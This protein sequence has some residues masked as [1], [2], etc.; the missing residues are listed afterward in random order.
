MSNSKEEKVN[1]NPDRIRKDIVL[2]IV[3]FALIGAYIFYEC[4]TATHVE[5]ETI[6]AVTSTVYDSV[7]AKALVVRDEHLVNG[8][9]GAVTVP[10]VSDGEKVKLGGNIAMVFSSEDNAKNYSDLTELHNQLDY[11]NELESKA[12]GT[13]TDVASI[14]KDILS[15]VN[16]YIRVINSNSYSSL[17]SCTDDLND[18]LARRQMIIGQDIDFSAVKENLQ[19]QINGINVDSCKPTGYITTDESGIFSSYTDGFEST[20][21]YKKITSVD[22]DTLRSY[23]ESAGTVQP[24]ADCIGKLIMDYNWY[25]CCVLSAEDVKEIS[26]GD[27]LNVSLKD[28]DK[29]LNCEVVSG[30]DVPLGQ[31]ETVLILKCSEIDGEITSMRVE[32]IEIRFNEYSGFKVPASA[33]HIDE[34][35]NKC[36]YALIA[37][38]VAKRQSEIIYST[39]DYVVFDRDSENSDSIRFYDQI[40]TKGKDLHDGKIYS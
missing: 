34:D 1:N 33:V 40:I 12:A 38:Q 13:A 3:M 5:V 35:G 14:D 2:I 32:N 11:Y 16:D 20:F 15:D 4:Y 7:E 26:D 24:Q 21:D 23:L 10:C 17:S 6:T 28:S 22:V 36:V 27:F 30:A 39:K 9:G 25:F 18:K 19:S 31:A 29:V 37:N 8:N